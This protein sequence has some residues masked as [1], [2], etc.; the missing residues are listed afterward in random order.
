[1]KKNLTKEQIEIEGLAER[2]PQLTQKQKDWAVGKYAYKFNY[3][4]PLKECTCP[5]CRHSVPIAEDKQ[6][7]EVRCPHCGVKIEAHRYYDRY[8]KTNHCEAFF[9]VMSAV[10]EWQITRLIY[11][12][13][14]CYVR[15]ESTPWEFYEV[16][17]AWNNPKYGTTYF[18][19]LPKNGMG[20][21][22]NPYSLHTWKYECTNA[23]NW[24]FNK[25]IEC[26]N[27]LEARMPASRNYFD[28]DNIAPYAEIAP[29]YKMMG[30]TRDSINATQFSALGLLEELSG[31]NYNPMRETLFKD[32]AFDLFNEL[33]RKGADM[34]IVSALFSAYRIC[35][36]NKYDYTEYFNEWK[37]LVTMLLDLGLDYRSPHYVCPSDLHD[38]HQRVLKMRL[39]SETNERVRSE[40]IGKVDYEERVARFLDMDIHND[41][42]DI[43]VLPNVM[44]FKDEAD[45]LH[46]C[47]FRCKYYE[48]ADSLILSA[49]NRHGRAK[50]WETIEVNLN[51]FQIKQSYGYGDKHTERHDEIQRLVMD[52]MWQIKER[53]KGRLKAAC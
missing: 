45:H 15:K 46:H 51:T 38:M 3:A 37:D 9:Q 19:S 21:H 39:K 1:M 48:K 52:N 18:R 30:I 44:A 50:R 42:L 16:C 36:R 25:Y 53:A 12:Q 2:V 14:W 29:C 22:Y 20:Y 17:Q 49:R 35:K 5:N 27:V 6:T 7:Q 41:S 32:G 43:I 31:R 40:L 23:D 47:V 4:R 26:D 34:R 28:T 33:T 24:T 13:R 10:G 8:F 11:M